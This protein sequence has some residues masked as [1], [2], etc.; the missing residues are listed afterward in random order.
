VNR[1]RNI[2]RLFFFGIGILLL[3]NLNRKTDENVESIAEFKLRMIQKVQNDSLE[4]KRKLDL[5]MDDT[6]EFVD[7]SSGVRA[8]VRYLSLLLGL[9]VVT[10]FAFI[11]FIR[12][13]SRP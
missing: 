9:V 10:E 13:S 12:Q 8:G 6:S 2:V 5:L 7:K 1:A 3:N 11:L 4:T